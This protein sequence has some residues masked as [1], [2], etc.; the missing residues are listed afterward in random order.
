MIYLRCD[1]ALFSNAYLPYCLRDDLRLEWWKFLFLF[2]FY[3]IGMISFGPNIVEDLSS[4]RL[5]T[6]MTYDIVL[7][8]F[9]KSRITRQL[10][11]D[12]KGELH[13]RANQNL[14]SPLFTVVDRYIQTN[15]GNYG[16]NFTGEVLFFVEWEQEHYNEVCIWFYV[17]GFWCV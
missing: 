5:H 4:V 11:G 9:S 7:P 16:V 3:D 12:F 14:Q 8:F 17:I 13:L 6:N 10:D 15:G 2:Q 1:I